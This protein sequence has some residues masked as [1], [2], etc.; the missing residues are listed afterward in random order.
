MGK[1][2]QS[3]NQQPASSNSFQISKFETT[4]FAHQSAA[5]LS[6]LADHLFTF[7]L[8]QFKAQSNPVE[9]VTNF[10]LAGQAYF[11]FYRS[12]ELPEHRDVL[13][14]Y[15][16]ALPCIICFADEFLLTQFS[17]LEEWRYCWPPVETE[18]CEWNIVSELNI[19]SNVRRYL[20]ETIKFL[21][22]GEL[23]EHACSEL[24]SFL[25]SNPSVDKMSIAKE[26]SLGLL[27]LQAIQNRQP[28]ECRHHILNLLKSHQQ[29]SCRGQLRGNPNGVLAMQALMLSKIAEQRGLDLQLQEHYPPLQLLA[30]N[31]AENNDA[32]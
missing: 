21:S 29:R 19:Q 13:T 7:A 30:V 9:I 5:Q 31:V 15:Y 3:L 26:L 18:P 23:D 17:E 25:Q 22:N 10:G 4:D 28:E 27:A 12:E 16:R 11:R 8:D 1:H 32:D 24:N 6:R 14:V 20:R 2:V